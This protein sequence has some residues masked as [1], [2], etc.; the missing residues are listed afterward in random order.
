MTVS[1]AV[2]A[3][4]LISL[5]LTPVMCSLFLK[6]HTPGGEHTTNRVNRWAERG[7]DAF[8][9]GY[10]RG[11][12]FVLRHQLPAL[13]VTLGLMVLTGYLY[14]AIPKGFFPQQDTGFIF[15]QVQG[16]QDTSF[17]QMQ[18]L[19]Q[20]VEQIVQ[21]DPA[22]EAV[23]YMAG[24]YAYNPTEDAARMYM[25]LKPHEE[26]N[27]TAQQVIERLRPQVAAVRGAKF[28]M[29]AGQDINVGGRLSKTQFQYTLTDTNSDELN[30]WAPLLE[31]TMR[32]LPQLEDVTSDQEIAAPHLS[33][34]IDRIAA[35]RLGLNMQTIDDTLYDAFGQRQR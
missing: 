26:R 11:L 8:L 34:E 4:A 7:F 32:K 18:K 19:A 1:V 30:H 20:Q 24:T 21:K 29:Q 17:E 16:R 10:D 31:D 27:V 6:P 22:V 14:V 2:I 12:R 3:S 9:N 23:F 15:G 5:T 25:Q 33:V 28:F 35:S 13:V